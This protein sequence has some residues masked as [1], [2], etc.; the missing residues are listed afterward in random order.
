MRLAAARSVIAA[1]K[2]AREDIF[3]WDKKNAF[4]KLSDGADALIARMRTRR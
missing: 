2:A 1:S 3:T 4:E